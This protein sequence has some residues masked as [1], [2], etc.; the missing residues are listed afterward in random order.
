MLFL[1]VKRETDRLETIHRSGVN[2]VTCIFCPEHVGVH[3][4]EKTD[5]LSELALVK[6]KLQHDENDVIKALWHKV[7][8]LF[9]LYKNE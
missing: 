5:K 9:P 7:W 3:S 4:N 1:G 2:K 8:S 6:V